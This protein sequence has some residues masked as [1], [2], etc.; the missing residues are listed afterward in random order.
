M[1]LEEARKTIRNA[2]HIAVL[3]GAGM[4]TESGLPDFRSQKGIYNTLTTALTFRIELFRIYPQRF[5]RVIGPFYQQCVSAE[6]NAGHRALA[7]L[8][9]RGKTVEIATQNVDCLHQKAGSS[10]V[11]E[12]HGTIDTVSCRKCHGHFKA[13]QFATVF[14]QGKVPHCPTC[15]KVLKPDLVFFGEALPDEP[16]RLAQLA[17]LNADL[18]MVLGTSLKVGP[19]NQLPCCRVDGTPLFIINQDPT[20][21]DD[22]AD[23]VSHEKIGEILPRLIEA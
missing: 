11:Y 5:Y 12:V 6:P 7:E 3:S 20:C 19:A 9:R 13:S 8:E 17:F 4:S 18:A 1:N 2:K 23:F 15:G 10:H 22:V 16:M 14:A 21:L